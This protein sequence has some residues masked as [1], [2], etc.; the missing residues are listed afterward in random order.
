MESHDAGER[1]VDAV[2][3]DRLLAHQPLGLARDQ[4]RSAHAI[5]TDIHQRAAVER[6]AEAHVGG[7]VGDEPERRADDPYP[8]D[9]LLR[10]ELG[11]PARLRVVPVHERLHQQPVLA[12]GHIEGAL[13]LLGATAQRLLAQDVLAGLERA[14]RP[15]DMHRVRERDVDDLDVGVGEQRVIAAVSP[16]DAVLAGIFVGALPVT[17]RHRENLDVFGLACARE[18]QAVDVRG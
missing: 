6:G 11:Q 3:A 5:A 16:L 2:A 13:D 1:D 14:D 7:V 8:A 12:L 4:A 18:E 15:V 9:R 17:A 10:D